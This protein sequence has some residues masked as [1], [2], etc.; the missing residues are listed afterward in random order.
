M[1]DEET[2]VIIDEPVN[3]E[4]IIDEPVIDEPVN[5]ETGTIISI[6]DLKKRLR[7]AGIDYSDYTDEDLTDLINLV[8][9]RIEAETGL[10]VLSPRMVTEYVD[11][12]NGKVYE[13]DFYP[14][15]GYEIR[16]NDE[17]FE[18]HRVDADRGIIYFKPRTVGEL[19]V[20][21][22]IQYTN[23]T[24]LSS[25]ISDMIILEMEGD[26]VH[27]TWNSIREGEVSVTYG[28]GSGGLQGKVDKALNE[29]KGYYKPRVRLL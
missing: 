3:D 7:L 11:L 22:Q 19:E 17:P 27:G 25:L 28:V 1:S 4:P 29:L 18:V 26:T 9:E 21:Y 5:E 8:I 13:T 2:E 15:V 23:N 16:L 20:K 10:P 14:L 6:A 12:F 24:V